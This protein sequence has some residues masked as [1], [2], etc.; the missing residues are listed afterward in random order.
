MGIAKT[1]LDITDDLPIDVKVGQVLRFT[2][3]DS[4]IVLKITS[5]RDGRVWARHL[6]P[7]KY[8]TPEEAD[9]QVTVKQNDWIRNREN[10][11]Y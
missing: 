2:F 6:D 5:K 9:D 10:H 7:K 4:P 11:L 1:W 8:L 3:E